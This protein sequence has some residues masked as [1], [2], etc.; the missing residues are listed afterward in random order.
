[1]HCNIF[2]ATV[3]VIVGVTSCA[4]Q[5]RRPGTRVGPES[6]TSGLVGRLT[7][8]RLPR[9]SLFCAR[10]RRTGDRRLSTQLG[11]AWL[12]WAGRGDRLA[13]AVFLAGCARN[14]RL[15]MSPLA[16]DLL[17]RYTL[18]EPWCVAKMAWICFESWSGRAR[19]DISQWTICCSV[20][21]W[22]PSGPIKAYFRIRPKGCVKLCSS[23]GA[24][25]PLDVLIVS[26]ARFDDASGDILT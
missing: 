25:R 9:A 23:Y 16:S 22:L 11:R 8:N 1:V 19:R 3:T 5:P 17:L 21:V 12:G 26:G 6:A 2:G 20:R 14:G 15:D 4:D 7:R 13:R 24:G 18:V 10:M